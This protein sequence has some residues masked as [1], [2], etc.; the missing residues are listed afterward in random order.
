[1]TTPLVGTVTYELKPLQSVEEYWQTVQ[2]HVQSAQRHHVRLLVF[3]EYQ[4]AQLL[5]LQP[6]MTHAEA[7]AY[8]DSFTDQ[9][10]EHFSRL[11]Q[12]NEM[13]I[14]GGTHIV[15]EGD[16]YVNKAYLFYPDGRIE[17][18]NKVHTTPEER[19]MW[20][21]TP[22]EE[23]AVF[24][25]ELGKA[26]IL[27]CYDIEFPETARIV[28]DMGAEIILCPS[29]TDAAAGFYRVRYCAQARAVENQL[30]VVMSGLVGSVPGVEQI[31]MAY[32]QGG[33]FAPCDYP[34]APDGILADGV[35][36]ASMVTTAPIDLAQL[37][38]NRTQGN[39]SPYYDRKPEL[40]AKYPSVV[41]KA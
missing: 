6:E 36:N 19:K 18:Q 3:P 14:L 26:A 15:K 38:D 17:T 34:F 21:L 39:V 28:A 1:M 13:T 31:D 16:G 24:D 2:M 9:Y 7:I 32:S 20:K 40:Y 27:T 8:L 5:A 22:G 41:A 35:L 11:A 23:F 25:T 37:H 4:T 10:V 12:E 29:Y 30:F 33:V